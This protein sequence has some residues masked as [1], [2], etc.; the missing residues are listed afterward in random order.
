MKYG[1]VGLELAWKVS[2]D[3][4]RSSLLG[5]PIIELGIGL[6]SRISRGIELCGIQLYTL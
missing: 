1:L 2:W 6:E 5:F 3:D 4:V